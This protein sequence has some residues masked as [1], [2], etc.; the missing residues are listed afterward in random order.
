MFKNVGYFNLQVF[1]YLGFYVTSILCCVLFSLYVNLLR[2][3]IFT[4]GGSDRERGGGRPLLLVPGM[5]VN[6]RCRNGSLLW[7]GGHSG[8]SGWV[9]SGH[10]ELTRK[11]KPASQKQSEFEML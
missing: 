5:G 4:R 7:V 9:V 10:P 8:L 2:V 1:T 11:P 6:G 3:S